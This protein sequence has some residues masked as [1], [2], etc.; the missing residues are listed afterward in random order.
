MDDHEFKAARRRVMRRYMLRLTFI[1]NLLF[2]IL[3]LLLI[4]SDP[5]ELPENKLLGG[6]VFAL[7]WSAL[8]L[9]HGSLAFN[10]FG[11][12]ID[13]AARRELEQHQPEE[14]PKR[15]RLELGEDGELNEV[16]DDWSPDEVE[17]RR[18]EI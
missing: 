17:K 2:F 11:G 6:A 3:I 18:E 1:F 5:H 10:L 4:A 9:L 8:L 7:I 14:K 12:L 13:R 16:M 15:Y